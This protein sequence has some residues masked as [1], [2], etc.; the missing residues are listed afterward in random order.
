MPEQIELDCD[1]S[2][3]CSIKRD[4]EII[5]TIEGTYRTLVYISI[6]PEHR[7]NGYGRAAVEQYLQEA[8]ARDV[9]RIATTT[10]IHSALERILQDLGFTPCPQNPDHME[11]DLQS[12][13]Q[14]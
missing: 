1:D 12:G 13:T 2:G 6:D 10:V 4:G 3:S 11:L 8:E 7:D 5:G 14:P 9:Q